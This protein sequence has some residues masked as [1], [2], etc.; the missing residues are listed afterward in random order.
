MMPVRVRLLHLGGETD[1]R[2]ELRRFGM[3]PG[4]ITANAEAIVPRFGV[5]VKGLPPAAVERIRTEFTSQDGLVILEPPLQ[6]TGAPQ[7][8]LLA[9]NAVLKRLSAWAGSQEHE[10]TSFGSVLTRLLGHA[11]AR[12]DRLLGAG[13]EL[14]LDR[15]RIMGILN[16][17]PDS[18]S[19]GGRYNSLDAARRRAAAMAAEGAD[20]IDIGGE[21][22]RPGAA[23]TDSEEE[24]TRVLPVVEALRS[25]LDLPLSIDTT[26]SQVAQAALQAGA[27]FINDISGL[28]ND[29]QI[30]SVVAEHDAGLFLMHMRGR[31]LD[32]QRDTG[33]QDLMGEICDFLDRGLI[34]A[35][36]RGVGPEHLAIDPGIGFG[37]SPDGNLEI[38]RRLSELHGLGRPILLGTSRKSFIGRL[39]NQSDPG[40]RLY[41]SLASIAVGVANGG[42]IFR[43][44]DVGPSREAALVAW[45]ICQSE[46]KPSSL[47]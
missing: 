39:L 43:V 20:L 29:S 45:A 46:G 41:G 47:S 7:T 38:L 31:P 37:K 23:P 35:Q 6:E 4:E 40:S 34:E 1:C 2:A 17:T 42:Q 13:C 16:V 3:S 25:D 30:A 15:P 11:G 18:F 32:M 27:N 24:L 9:G 5:L 12:P 36:R 8:L 14:R 19:D 10:L 28:C 26:K 22:T 44:H 33:Y 21:S